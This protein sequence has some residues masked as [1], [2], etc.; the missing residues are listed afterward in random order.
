MCIC[1]M[2]MCICKHISICICRRMPHVRKHLAEDDERGPPRPKP[3]PLAAK[4]AAVLRAYGEDNP[5]AFNEALMEYGAQVQQ[6]SPE[7]FDKTGFEVFYN[8]L[9]AFM[10]S[11]QP[12]LLVFVL[13]CIGWLR[14]CIAWPH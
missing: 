5:R 14:G 8:R 2:R 7:A 12:Y 1:I 4:F 13:S 11:A 9:G 3:D 10:K 6:E